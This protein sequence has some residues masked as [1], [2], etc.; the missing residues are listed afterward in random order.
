MNWAYFINSRKPI[1]MHRRATIANKFQYRTKRPHRHHR[2]PITKSSIR[3]I[4]SKAPIPIAS[5]KRQ[6]NA[7]A[8][9]EHYLPAIHRSHCKFSLEFNINFYVPAKNHLHTI[10]FSA[11]MFSFIFTIQFPFI[12]RSPFHAMLFVFAFCVFLLLFI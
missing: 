6:M 9:T 2:V 12:F 8:T 4:Q 1:Q 3:W 7:D 11:S 5:Q 10:N